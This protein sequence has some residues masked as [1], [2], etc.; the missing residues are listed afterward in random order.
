YKGAA[1][2]SYMGLAAEVSVTILPKTLR[3]SIRF[4]SY[5]IAPLAGK[6]DGVKQIDVGLSYYVDGM[7][8]RMKIQP[9]LEMQLYRGDDVSGQPSKKDTKFYI[10][11]SGLFK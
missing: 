1:A 8:H 5:E 7:G 11:F 2:E 3:G 4:D 10:L 9:Q 6:K